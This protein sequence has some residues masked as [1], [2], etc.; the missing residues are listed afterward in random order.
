ML[1]G[2]YAILGE[3]P[4]H[5]LNMIVENAK[6]RKLFGVVKSFLYFCKKSHP[7]STEDTERGMKIL[8]L[9][10]HGFDPASGISKKM[11]AQIKGLRQNGHEVHVCSYDRDE[12]GHLCRFIDDRPIRDYGKGKWAAIMQRMDYRCIFDYCVGEGIE[13][14]Y[15]RSYM[16]ATPPLV[17]LFKRLRKAGIKSVMEVPTYP[18]DQEFK[19]YDWNQRM[20]LH[21]DQ[22]YRER[23]S[24]QMEAIVT[25]SDEDTI[26]GQRTIR[27][28]NGVDLDA[29]PL[30][31]THPDTTHEVHLIAVAEV[32][33]WH[34]FDRLI[35][36]LGEYYANANVNVNANG[37]PNVNANPNV[38]GNPEHPED[39]TPR[40]PKRKV[41]FHIVG[42]VWPGEM[43]GSVNA[44]GFAPYIKEYNIE[45]Y[46]I[47]HGK[48]FGEELDKVFDL[49]SFAVGSLGRHRS[50][51][52]VI[53]TLKN[54][55]YASRGLPF[56]YSEQ[57]SD[58]DH[59]PYVLKAPADESAID[60]DSILAFLDRQQ[61]TPAEI[62]HTVEH[63]SWKTQ[64]QRV[65]DCFS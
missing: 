35:H 45:E 33:T 47:F 52:T 2:Q 57:D 65:V 14:I 62:R 29:I 50:G 30:H 55:E 5:F 51:I 27:I 15:V 48:L 11:L 38:N 28:S 26:F 4:F 56:V 59:Q 10:Y 64:M 53:K 3:L 13:F 31:E 12:R 18:Y 60:I 43:N 24:A 34:G 9:T 17:R 36:G 46:V 39:P 20:R 8:F 58:F 44:P 41:Y 7:E 23:L 22:R 40:L 32:H 61:M 1:T 6:K 42:D 54:R 37:N 25:F 21:I 19:G 16:N 63:L 49:C